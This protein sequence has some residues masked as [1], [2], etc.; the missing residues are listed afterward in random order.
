MERYRDDGDSFYY[1]IQFSKYRLHMNRKR[2]WNSRTTVVTDIIGTFIKL[3]YDAPQSWISESCLHEESS[4]NLTTRN[5]LLLWNLINILLAWHQID[6]KF[7]TSYVQHWKRHVV[8]IWSRILEFYFLEWSSCV[9][10]L[11]KT[12]TYSNSKFLRIFPENDL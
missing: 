2:H 6:I 1:V 10:L 12:N 5:Y 11:L 9:K 7:R 4:W 3:F 8:P